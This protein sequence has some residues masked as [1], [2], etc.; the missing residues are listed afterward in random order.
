MK[1]F[2]IIFFLS[3]TL[4]LYGQTI[5]LSEVVIPREYNFGF[6]KVSDS[7]RLPDGWRSEG[8]YH[9][10]SYNYSID[11][12][13]KHSGKYA[14]LIESTGSTTERLNGLVRYLIPATY[15]GKKIQ[16]RVFMKASD[17][18][19]TIGVIWFYFHDGYTGLEEGREFS[20]HIVTTKWKR[21][22]TKK[23]PLSHNAKFIVIFL[24]LQGHGKIWL[25]D[26]EI[27]IDGKN[28]SKAKLKVKDDDGKP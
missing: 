27:L 25:D 5:D 19:Q 28:I 22:S 2:F 10:F 3:S 8:L 20:R 1:F 24:G 11:S 6:E 23:L 12:I 17:R 15:Q 26:V 7:Q 14:L 18:N 21:Y 13:T 9:T 16:L 4:L